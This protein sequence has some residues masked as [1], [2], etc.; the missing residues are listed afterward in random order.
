MKT[1]NVLVVGANRGIGL[2]LVKA[3]TAKSWHV[4]GTIRPQ[5]RNDESIKDLIATGADILEI[6]TLDESSIEKAAKDFGDKPL[7]LLLNLGGLSPHPKSWQEQTTE[8]FTDKFQTMAVGPF[9]TCKHFLASLEK[10]TDPKIVNITSEFGSVSSNSFGTCMAYRVAKAAANQM[11]VTLA[12]EWE[13][14]GRKVTVVCMEP[15]FVATRLTGWDFVDDMDTCIAGI[16]KVV[17][18]LQQSDNASFIKWD[19]SKIPF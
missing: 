9:L 1:K 18:G 4:T 11:T 8:M 13:K 10:A 14:E 12:R 7:D 15:G 17:D 6:D 5:S 3:Y 2:S 16:V 19:G